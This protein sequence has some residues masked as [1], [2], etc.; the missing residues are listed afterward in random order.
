MTRDG[1]PVYEVFVTDRA[2]Q[3]IEEAYLY[4]SSVSNPNRAAEWVEDLRAK[5]DDLAQFPGPRAYPI[6]EAAT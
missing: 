6:D 3:H 2:Y 1:E 4:V 5:I